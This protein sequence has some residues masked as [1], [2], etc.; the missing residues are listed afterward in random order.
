LDL[1]HGNDNLLFLILSYRKSKRNGLSRDFVA[2]L[3]QP[4]WETKTNKGG[5][6]I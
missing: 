6:L 5:N 3:W 1:D 2:H 4:S